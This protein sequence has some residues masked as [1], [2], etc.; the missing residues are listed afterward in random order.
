ML[1][2]VRTFGLRDFNGTVGAIKK[3][4]DCNR[5]NFTL[6]GVFQEFDKLFHR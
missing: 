6:Q 2:M 3:Q 5:I 4:A 1:T